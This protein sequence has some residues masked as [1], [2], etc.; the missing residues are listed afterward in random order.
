MVSFTRFKKIKKANCFYS[1]LDD[2]TIKQ[3]TSYDRMYGHTPIK[4]NINKNF[5]LVNIV[6]HFDYFMNFIKYKKKMDKLKI[7]FVLIN[8][9]IS[10]SKLIHIHIKSLQ[11]FFRLL[12]FLRKNKGLFK[13]KNKD[14]RNVLEPLLLSSFSGDIQI[15]LINAISIKNF[16]KV[17]HSN[18][19]VS[20][21]EFNPQSRSVY[22]FLKKGNVK[23]K[24]IGYQHS[25]CN[26][27][28]L[29]YYHRSNEFHKK[30]Y[31]EGI[32][33]SPS[34]DYYF[35]QGLQFKKLLSSYY[36]KKIC[37][38]GSLRYDLTKF[39]NLDKT[40]NKVK[41]ILICPSIGD[42]EMIIEFLNGL[43]TNNHRF[44]LCP[45]PNSKVETIKLFKKNF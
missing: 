23:I 28:V 2:I 6:K 25:Y 9:F 31:K 15:S 24:S 45:H 8:E 14:C 18:F 33:Y 36:K 37:I 35:V 44:I 43:D 10:Y 29:P 26:K 7:P 4:K 22:Y 19:F 12:I 17:S 34:P 13:I 27:N 16:F 39:N 1:I 3:N 20:Y 5:Y 38:I 41:K 40:N 42:A 21:I 11:F 30:F 32:T